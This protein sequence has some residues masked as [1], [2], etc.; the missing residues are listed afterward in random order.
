MND[1]PL[2]KAYEELRALLANPSVPEGVVSACLGLSEHQTKLF[3]T[4]PEAYGTE[5]RPRLIKN[6]GTLDRKCW[7]LRLEPS[8]FFCE[9]LTTLRAFEWPRVMVLIHEAISEDVCAIPEIA[10]PE[11]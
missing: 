4:V 7:G 3:T 11:A 2:V 10:S 9:L 8:N 5:D 1:A 6:A